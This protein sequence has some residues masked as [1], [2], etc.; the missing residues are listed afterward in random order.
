MNE[1]RELK[2]PTL[3]TKISAARITGGP[4]LTPQKIIAS[5]SDKEYEDFTE[6]WAFYV[7]RPQYSK[8]RRMGAA[9][10]MGIDVAAY[11][12]EPNNWRN[13]QCKH[14]DRPLAPGDV[15][16]EIGKLFYHHSKGEILLPQKYYF[17]APKGVGPSLSKLLKNPD[18]LKQGLYENWEK[19][20]QLKITKKE[21]VVLEGKLEE[22]I[23][24]TDFSMFDDLSPLEI[25]EQFRSS[26]GFAARF[27]G[28]LP[29]RPAHETPPIETEEIQLFIQKLLEAYSEHSGRAITSL[30]EVAKDKEY[31][32]H[33][34]Q[35][36]E[37]FYSAESLKTF[38]RDSLPVESNVFNDFQNEIFHGI[39]DELELS[40]ADGYT[41]VRHATSSAT[42]IPIYSNA[43]RDYASAVDKKGACHQLANDGRVEWTKNAKK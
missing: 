36:R 28:G 21:E 5:Y 30:D 14:Y 22:I 3:T 38:A 1:L 32:E 42:K 6:E 7:L 11:S 8:V 16:I 9:G 31:L 35:Q 29:D 33:L 15:W 18:K 20:C 12:D 17:V 19:H 25:I 34:K 23:E 26:Q 10:D 37:C 39:I 24:A 2:G 4:L 43:L 41:K 40:T 27:G 13:Y